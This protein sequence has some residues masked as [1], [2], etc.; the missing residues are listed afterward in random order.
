M[1]LFWSTS[2]PYARKVR[3]VLREKRLLGDVDEIECNP[4]ADPPALRAVNPLGLIPTLV[5][6]SGEAL[7]DS[8][9]ICAYLDAANATDCLIP[10]GTAQWIVRGAEALADGLLNLAVGLT[11]KLR[12]PPSE[13]SPASLAR[14]RHAA[15]EAI[16]EMDRMRARLPTELTLGHIAIACACSYLDFRPASVGSRWRQDHPALADWHARLEALPSFEQT[17]PSDGS[18][19]RF[20]SGPGSA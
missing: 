6:D 9:V 2:S 5:L 4:Y 14:R 8:P 17:R 19:L 16:A 10:S 7:Y 18:Y 1:K 3:I 13:Q 20:A 12:R 11:V 15:V